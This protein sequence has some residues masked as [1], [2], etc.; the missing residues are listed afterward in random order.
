[1]YICAYIYICTYIYVVSVSQNAGR[2]DFIENRDVKILKINLVGFVQ[3]AAS[4][5]ARIS[6]IKSAL[7]EKRKGCAHEETTTGR[8]GWAWEVERGK[9]LRDLN[10][11]RL[12]DSRSDLDLEISIVRDM[13]ETLVLLT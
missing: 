9:S 6:S 1:M 4:L 10:R 3:I 2:C 13:S 5:F 11:I 12:L 7:R 8:G